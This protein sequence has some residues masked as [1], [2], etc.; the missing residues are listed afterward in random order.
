[1]AANYGKA[2]TEQEPMKGKVLLVEFARQ[3]P[4]VP[5]LSW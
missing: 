2:N 3:S 4:L 1:M 5:S